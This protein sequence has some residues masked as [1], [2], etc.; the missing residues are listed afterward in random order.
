MPLESVDGALVGLQLQH[1]P[2]QFVHEPWKL[3]RADQ[4][5]Y[6]VRIGTYGAP[7]SDYPNPPKSV[8]QYPAD[9]GGKA[10]KGSMSAEE[11]QR[12]KL[13]NN[14]AHVPPIFIVGAMVP[15]L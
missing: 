10:S 7:D 8:F 14:L 1:V 5:K 13:G 12:T 9:G 3:S 4:E 6:G 11:L 15:P 2:A